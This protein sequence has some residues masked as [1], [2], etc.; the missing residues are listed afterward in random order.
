VEPT[1]PTI[2]GAFQSPCPAA[3]QAQPGARS[4]TI[5]EENALKAYNEELENEKAALASKNNVLEALLEA[6][7]GAPV[8][9]HGLLILE[10]KKLI[11]IIQTLT[12]ADK[13]EILAN[14][15]VGCGCCGKNPYF[16]VS[17]IFCVTEGKR[18]E[19]KVTFNEEYSL[20]IRHGVS[21][22]IVRQSTG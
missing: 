17:K 4:L 3:N 2:A 22:K 14:D 5:A 16:T 15:P 18:A 21:V 12:Q 1:T 8:V 6:Y 20:L 11:E 9:L 13:V 7:E 10:S 19:F